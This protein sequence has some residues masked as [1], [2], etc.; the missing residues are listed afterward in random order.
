MGHLVKQCY[1][2]KSESRN[3][4][5][6]NQKESFIL[7]INVNHTELDD[8]WL[9]D[10]AATH[11]VCKSE[12]LFK[13]LRKIKPEPVGTAETMVNQGQATLMAEGIGDITLSTNEDN[14]TYEI[15]LKD[16]YY[17]PKCKWNLLSVA[18]IEKKGKTV[19]MQHGTGKIINN[20]TKKVVATAYRSDNLYLLQAKIVKSVQEEKE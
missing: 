7:S 5:R 20:A 10:S 19:V 1:K 15:T 18:Q 6:L 4:T 2:K 8:A 14:T 3:Q 11:H 9:L 17:I 16:V 12:Q 13:N